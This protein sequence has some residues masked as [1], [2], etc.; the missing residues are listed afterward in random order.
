V[1]GKELSF[2]ADGNKGWSHFGRVWPFQTK[3]NMLYDSANILFDI[4]P[5]ELKI[6]TH[7]NV[8]RKCL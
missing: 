3:L 4:Y 5:N 8:I 2:L 1:E 6:Y 7:K